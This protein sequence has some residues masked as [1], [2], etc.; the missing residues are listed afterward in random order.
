[1]EIVIGVIHDSFAELRKEREEKE[2]LIQTRCF[3][4]DI[5][6]QRFDM[7]ANENITFV[8]H[9]KHDHNMWNYVFFLIYLFSKD[10][11]KFTGTEHYIFNLACKED[12]S[13]FPCLRSLTLEESDL[14]RRRRNKLQGDQKKDKAEM[15][16]HKKQ[17][18][19]EQDDKDQ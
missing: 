7:R 16:K 9:T 4:C 17:K 19:G 8:G 12:T 10:Y 11:T 14:R 15:K 5:E 13:F 18:T 3:I 6:K 2:L 1:M